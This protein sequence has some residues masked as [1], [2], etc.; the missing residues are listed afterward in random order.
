MGQQNADKTSLFN[1][2]TI[3]F[4]SNVGS[5]RNEV[6]SINYTRANTFHIYTAQPESLFVVSI[7]V[8]RP[9]FAG[10]GGQ[11]SSQVQ[12]EANPRESIS[13][14]RFNFTDSDP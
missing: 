1:N 11:N 9:L 10:G 14:L 8:F 12:S 3:E 4:P 13:I 6:E 7:L 2:L 5:T